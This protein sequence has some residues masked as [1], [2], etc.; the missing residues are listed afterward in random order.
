M[1][2]YIEKIVIV[3]LHLKIKNKGE[4]YSR[5]LDYQIPVTQQMGVANFV[6]FRVGVA[7]FSL[8]HEFLKFDRLNR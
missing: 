7:N 5:E 6:G 1:T 8:G 3:K 4:R 2:N